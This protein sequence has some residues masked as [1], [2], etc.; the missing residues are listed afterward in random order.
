[1][2]IN[3]DRNLKAKINDAVLSERSRMNDERYKDKLSHQKE[4]QNLQH[5]VQSLQN[6]V[7]VSSNQIKGDVGEIIIKDCLEKYFPQFEVQPIK[8]G[9]NGGD[10]ILHYRRGS[11][12][13]MIK[14][15]SK[16][17]K[18]YNPNWER[19]LLKDMKDRGIMYGLI[20]TEVMPKDK[21]TPFMVNG[22]I[23]VCK[24]DQFLHTTSLILELFN[25]I[26]KRDQI[27]STD[28]SEEIF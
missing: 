7:N 8:K 25:Q 5:Q 14:Y 4:I 23:W 26:Y 2:K 16:R 28:K 12:H 11:F 13:Y 17:V 1:M 6:S 15:E 24:F 10:C 27:N 18:N 22:N 9:E 21:N 19:K 20:V 3:A